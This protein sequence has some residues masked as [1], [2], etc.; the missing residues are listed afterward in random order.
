MLGKT[1]KPKTRPVLSSVVEV[2]Y[3]SVL[4]G[5]DG[6]MIAENDQAFPSVVM[7]EIIGLVLWVDVGL[8]GEVIGVLLH[9]LDM[10]TTNEG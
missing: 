3:V 1:I 4:V 10:I 8:D 2:I 9:Q 7:I 5:R 6:R